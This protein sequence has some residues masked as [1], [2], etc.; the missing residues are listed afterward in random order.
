MTKRNLSA[1]DV[2]DEVLTEMSD[3]AFSLLPDN[4]LIFRNA[5]IQEVKQYLIE[6]S[7]I[8]VVHE[9]QDTEEEVAEY[10]QMLRD[11]EWDYRHA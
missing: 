3:R 11:R 2:I 9:E 8:V 7:D 1:W 5:L 10:E 6:N 4:R